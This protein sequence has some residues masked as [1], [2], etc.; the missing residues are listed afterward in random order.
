MDVGAHP[1]HSYFSGALVVLWARQS[2]RI[3]YA[4][5]LFFVLHPSGQVT[6]WKCFRAID[7]Q[8]TE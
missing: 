8:L 2:P 3:L 6:R 7:S 5:A 1:M 4:P